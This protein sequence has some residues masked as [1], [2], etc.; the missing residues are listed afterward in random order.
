[1]GSSKRLANSNAILKN[2]VLFSS[3]YENSNGL[4]PGQYHV[5]NDNLIKKSFNI[6]ASS[7]K[8]GSSSNPVTPRGAGGSRGKN[9]YFFHFI[10]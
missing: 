3:Q 4:G 2:G 8:I 10:L 6:R 7:N 5:S 1:M 9:I